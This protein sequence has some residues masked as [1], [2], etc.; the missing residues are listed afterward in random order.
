MPI[1]IKHPRWH[2]RT[3]RR[4][5]FAAFLGLGLL[6]TLITAGWCFLRHSPGKETF[7]AR[8]LQQEL[9]L[10][11]QLEKFVYVRPGVVRYEG[12]KLFEPESHRLLLQCRQMEVCRRDDQKSSQRPQ[13]ELFVEGLV[14]EAETLESCRRWLQYV[15]ENR[16]PLSEVD[17]HLSAA[18]ACLRSGRERLHLYKISGELKYLPVGVQAQFSFYP[19]ENSTSDPAKLRLLRDR[20]TQPISTLCELYTGGSDWPCRRLGVGLPLLQALGNQ[21]HFRGYFWGTETPSGWEGDLAG[22]VSNLDLGALADNFLPYQISGFGELTIHRA[23]FRQGRLQE[24]SGT[25]IAGPGKIDRTLLA[26]AA[27]QLGL[28][29]TEPT[30]L[31]PVNPALDDRQVP[32]RQLAFSVGLSVEGIQL[33]GQCREAAPGT[34]LVG[35]NQALLLA[36]QPRTYP[37]TRLVQ[38][39]SPSGANPAS[40]ISR[41]GDWLLRHLPLP[42]AAHPRLPEAILPTAKHSRPEV[43]EVHQ[44]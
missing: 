11:V 9:G 13:L 8:R 40:S 14:I 30:L 19:S 38:I 25:L 41:Q 10:G 4:V 26:A 36:S 29:A 23:R 33:I 6:P 17:L 32:F 44:R 28:Y 5:C 16:L 31:R 15:L 3:Q 2:E 39:L 7:A 37:V 42:E 27:E 21:A 22:R 18:E 20:R 12:L 35:E 24:G 1:K 34:I 43:P